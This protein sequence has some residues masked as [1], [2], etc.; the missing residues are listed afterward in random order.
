MASTQVC[1]TGYME[2]ENTLE[3]R[4]ISTSSERDAEVQLHTFGHMLIKRTNY[5]QER[6][7]VTQAKTKKKVMKLVDN[8]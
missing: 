6:R 1:F 5:I 4:T 2:C 8:K 7:C 3:D